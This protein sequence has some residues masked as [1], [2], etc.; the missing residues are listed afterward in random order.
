MA[1]WHSSGNSLDRL[2]MDEVYINADRPVC[3]SSRAPTARLS[4][5]HLRSKN[6]QLASPTTDGAQDPVPGIGIGAYRQR[7]RLSWH[8]TWSGMAFWFRNWGDRNAALQTSLKNHTP[9][10]I[11]SILP[12]SRLMD[13][14]KSSSGPTG[15]GYL[16]MYSSDWFC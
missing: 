7:K 15:T 14:R 1:C 5:S 3:E 16:K 13:R 12:L 8:R 11:P 4:L 2:H 10:T 6:S 9:G